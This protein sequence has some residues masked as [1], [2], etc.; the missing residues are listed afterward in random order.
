MGAIQYFRAGLNAVSPARQLHDG[1]P[2][3]EQLG[4]GSSEG[5]F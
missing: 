2:G 4:E 3:L 5:H 1:G